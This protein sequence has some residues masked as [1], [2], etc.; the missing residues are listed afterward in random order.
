MNQWSQENHN[1]L[2]HI[3]GQVPFPN[4]PLPYRPIPFFSPLSIP[5]A[6]PFWLIC[7]N[8]LYFRV[9]LTL[10]KVCDR[11]YNNQGKKD[12]KGKRID[13]GSLKEGRDKSKGICPPP[14]KKK[15]KKE[16]EKEKEK[17]R[18]YKPQEGK[19]GKRRNQNFFKKKRNT[20]KVI[21]WRNLVF[22]QACVIIFIDEINQSINQSI[23]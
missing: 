5:F 2:S 18:R 10:S 17:R 16:K 21:I 8:I 13:R 7:H 19:N 22:K 23:N 6:Y 20:P 9:P 14:P 3:V 12:R 4:A 1:S 11:P 15:K